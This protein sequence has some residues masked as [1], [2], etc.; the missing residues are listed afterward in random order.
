MEPPKL[1]TSINKG[2]H[3]TFNLFRP[4]NVFKQSIRN[5]KWRMHDQW[6]LCSKHALFTIKVFFFSQF[7]TVSGCLNNMYCVWHAFV[8]RLQNNR[9]IYTQFF[10][11]VE[12]NPFWGGERLHRMQVIQ[13]SPCPI[14]HWLIFRVLLL[15]LL[16]WAAAL[17]IRIIFF[18]RSKS[19]T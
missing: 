7:K 19:N 11:P 1:F 10:C 16:Q 5:T 14:N 9:P 18:G 15:W 13:P 8:W 2:P 12:M 3:Y 4:Q 17:R 6:G